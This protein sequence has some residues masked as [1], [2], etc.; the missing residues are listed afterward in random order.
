MVFIST[1]PGSVV[2]PCVV[3]P[4]MASVVPIVPVV[5][6]SS[7]SLLSRSCN[8]VSIILR[9][10]AP[11]SKENAP[12]TRATAAAPRAHTKSGGCRL[13]EGQGR[14]A[15]QG[16]ACRGVAQTLS[17]KSKTENQITKHS[18]GTGLRAVQGAATAQHRRLSIGNAL[19]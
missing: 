12:P 1:G 14:C 3:I 4:T 15:E 8:L 10:F 2:L 18:S 17:K 19:T 13:G 11:C 7:L 6:S 5:A 16:A 9:A